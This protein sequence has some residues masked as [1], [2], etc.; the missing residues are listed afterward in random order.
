MRRFE[1]IALTVIVAAIGFSVAAYNITG[2]VAPTLVE[3]PEVSNLENRYYASAP[4]LTSDSFLDKTFQDEFDKFLA[5]HVP[6]RDQAVLFN[7]AMQRTSVAT[8]AAIRGFKVYPSFFESRYYVV[9]E[10]GLIVDRAEQLPSD[11]SMHALDAWVDTLNEAAQQHPDVR[12]VYDCVARHDQT[13]ANPTY[14]YYDDRL[15][16]AWVQ[17]HLVERLDP[18]IDAFVDAVQ[19]YDEIVEKWFSTDPHWT[20]ER[21]LESYNLVASRLGLTQYPYENPVKVVR[22]WHGSYARS[23]LDLDFP[24]DM[25]D[26]PIDF[27]QLSFYDLQEDGGAPKYMG[28]REAVLNNGAT[29]E[30]SGASEYYRYFGGGSTEVTNSGA[31]NGK[32]LLFVGDSLSYCLSRFIASNYS[33]SVFLLPG[34]GR[35][36]SSLE[37]YLQLY[38]PDDV[39]VMMHASKFEMIAEYSPA[40]MGLE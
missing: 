20:L 17:E 14:R 7:A 18:R 29:L 26:L 9:P 1:N 11:S 35:F 22:G 32:K 24:I 4:A 33:Q 28:E 34:N 3:V 39:I 30:T 13:E 15:D 21:A 6:V 8:S 37:D 23:G 5:D 38:K 10:D 31:H 27:S 25:E 12:F 36:T 40:F 2:L 19:S 16:P